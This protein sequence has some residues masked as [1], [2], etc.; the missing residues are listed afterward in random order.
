VSTNTGLGVRLSENGKLVERITLKIKM[1]DTGSWEWTVRQRF[2]KEPRVKLEDMLKILD[3]V[4]A[5]ILA[6]EGK[7]EMKEEMPAQE[8]IPTPNQ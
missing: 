2:V 5:E 6:T 8:T 7:S 3:E 4:K 1:F